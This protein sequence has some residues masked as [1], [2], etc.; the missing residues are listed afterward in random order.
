MGLRAYLMVSV[1]ED[2]E[3]VDLVKALRE[4]ENTSGIDFVDRVIGSRDVVVMVDSAVTVESIANKI[5]NLHWVKDL[6]VMRI[7]SLYERHRG[8]KAELLKTFSHAGA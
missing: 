6:E 8:S 4:L 2:I 1:A 5:R 3:Q 7:I